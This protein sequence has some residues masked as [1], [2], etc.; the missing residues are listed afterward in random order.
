MAGDDKQRTLEHYRRELSR[1][2]Y[3]AIALVPA[4]GAVRDDAV[5]ADVVAVASEGAEHPGYATLR[6]NAE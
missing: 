4:L 6:F 5:I 1:S 3:L 2:A